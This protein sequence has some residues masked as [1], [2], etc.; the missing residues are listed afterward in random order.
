MQVG[1]HRQ[2]R[3]FR[4]AAAG[5]GSYALVT[6]PLRMSFRVVVLPYRC[7][8]LVLVLLSWFVGHLVY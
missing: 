7:V 8:L 6:L 1:Q 2:N 3:C 4:P 5:L